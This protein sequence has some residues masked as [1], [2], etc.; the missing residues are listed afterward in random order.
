MNK[1]LAFQAGPGITARLHLKNNC[2]KKGWWCG[3]R[4]RVLA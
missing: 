1:K 4:G 2:S 3:S